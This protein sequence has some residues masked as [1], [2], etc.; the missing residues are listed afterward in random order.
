MKA[1]LHYDL[2][3]FFISVERLKDSR[4]NG[5]PIIVGGA[6]DRGVVASCSYETRIF[7]VHSG[8]SMKLARQ[9][10]PDALIIKGDGDAYSEYSKMVTDIISE[11]APIFEKASVDEFYVD[12]TGMDRFIGCFKWSVELRERVIRETGLPISLGLSTNK[13]VAKVATGTAKPNGAKQVEKGTEK[14]F[15][16]PM[17]IERIPMIGPKTTKTLHE[18]RVRKVKT[19]SE[20]PVEYLMYLFGK[21]GKTLSQRANGIDNSPVV[22]YSEAK[23]IS[24]ERTFN[25][26]T[27]DV[28]MLKSLISKMCE[29]LAFE[30]RNSNKLTSCITVKIRYSDF[31]THTLQQRIFYT[32]CDHH[33]IRYALELFKKLYT[34]RVLVR[35]VGV[36]LSGL[37]G[38]NYQ[39]NLFED[40]SK[41]MKLYQSVD[42]M[43]KRFGKHCVYRVSSMSDI[44]L[45]DGKMI[46]S[47]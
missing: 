24:K 39:M 19:L 34:R 38:G 17:N 9:L 28:D 30:L 10:C 43:K 31:D 42:R 8:M 16:A 36:K 45:R 12:M 47:K 18:M 4:L 14:P 20:I 6:N 46:I 7:G 21:N 15:L 44:E 27:I 13:M 41:I 2:D 3:T 40:S 29:T 23:S 33:L 35:L 22:P 5:R 11:E 26:D 1:I 25:Q 37:V 32:S